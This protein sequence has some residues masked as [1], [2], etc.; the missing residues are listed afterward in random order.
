VSERVLDPCLREGLVGGE[1][2][3]ID[4]SVVKAHAKRQR[5]LPASEI[6]WSKIGSIGRPAREH[7]TVLNEAEGERKMPKNVSLTDP[8]TYGTRPQET[9]S[10]IC[11]LMPLKRG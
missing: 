3:A 8:E 9:L 5:G 4:A 6:D 11:P 10:S 2:F 7:L 1:G